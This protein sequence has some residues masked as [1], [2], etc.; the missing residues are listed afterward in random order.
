MIWSAVILVLSAS[1]CLTQG[2]NQGSDSGIILANC[3]CTTPTLVMSEQARFQAMLG[4]MLSGSAW[5]TLLANRP[6]PQ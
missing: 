6:C 2:M 4:C 5:M 3:E 1:E